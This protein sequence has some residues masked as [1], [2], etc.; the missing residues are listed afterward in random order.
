MDATGGRIKTATLNFIPMY[1]LLTRNYLECAN[2]SYPKNLSQFLDFTDSPPP[3]FLLAIF[4]A[5]AKQK[6]SIIQREIWG[7]CMFLRLPGGV[8]W[9]KTTTL[10]QEINW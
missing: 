9:L 3:Y 10:K 1:L 2:F 4:S 6:V 8:Q 7:Y 5:V